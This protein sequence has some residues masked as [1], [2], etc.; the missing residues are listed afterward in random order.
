MNKVTLLQ[1]RHSLA[2]QKGQGQIYLP[3][4]ILTAASRII[5]AGGHVEIQDANMRPPEFTNPIVASNVVGAPYIPIV[6]EMK[7]QITAALGPNAQYILGGQAISGLTP[8]QFQRLFDKNTFDGNDDATL[9]KLL[10]LQLRKMPAPEETSL[11]PAYEKI[12]DEDFQEYLQHEFCLYL[13]QG[14]RFACDFCAANRNR[15]YRDPITGKVAKVKERYRNL[16]II[17]EELK[18]MIERAKRLGIN[19]FEIYL[20]NLDTFQTPKKLKQFAHIM[21]EIKRANPGFTFKMRCLATAE[22]FMKTY[23]DDK[24]T[25]TAM[26]DAGLWSIG[27]GVD[28]TSREVWKSIKK[29]HNK[30]DECI[31]SI[32]LTRKEFGITPEVLMVVGHKKDTPKTLI[33]DVEF[34]LDMVEN[35]GATIRPYVAKDMVPGNSGWA[36]PKNHHRVEMLM[37]HPEYFQALDFSALPTALTHPNK[38]MHIHIERAFTMMT[39]IPGN[40]TD[41]I[42]PISAEINQRTAQI[43][44]RLNRGKFDR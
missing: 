27:F 37:Q 18:Y 25:I 19:S 3:S 35:F 15:P 30:L 10:G 20:S 44:H 32:R 29:G 14:C 34:S 28:G 1:P 4:S 40:T 21:Q 22:H 8:D 17:D 36:D 2:P 11:I 38:R 33:D 12:S 43:R 6:I 42:Y 26:V 31:E 39:N 41:L 13:S 9:K 5:A 16:E 24:D 23:K 7:K